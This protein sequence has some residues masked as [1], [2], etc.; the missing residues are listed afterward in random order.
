MQRG[1]ILTSSRRIPGR[2]QLENA[3]A[4]AFR[5]Q[6]IA[7]AVIQGDLF[8]AERRLPLPHQ[9]LGFGDHGEITQGEEVEFQQSQLLQIILDKLA[10]DHVSADGKGI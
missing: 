6:G 10:E 2:F 4:V 9:T 3:L 1:R 7:F 8:D 5:E